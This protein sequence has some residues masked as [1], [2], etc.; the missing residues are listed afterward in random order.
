[1]HAF[2][3]DI[4]RHHKDFWTKSR[5]LALVTSLAFFGLALIIQKLADFYVG[6]LQ[7]VVVPDLLLDH[8]PTVDID[9]VIV[10]GA[11]LLTLVI[12]L[13]VLVKPKYIM[14]T[15]KA[16]AIFI[17]TRSFFISLTHLGVSPRQLTFDTNSFGFGLYNW[18]YNTTGDFFFSGHTG[19]PYLM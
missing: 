10:Q 5:V 1:M 13:L 3:K 11:L 7:G 6:I 9:V 12:I 14:F 17:I 15:L 8:L 18:M 2:L 16:L 19:T 4:F